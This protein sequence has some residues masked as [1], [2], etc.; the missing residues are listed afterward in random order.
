M[1]NQEAGGENV[2]KSL[3]P[4]RTF[5]VTFRGVD[6]L[7]V[8]KGRG[9]FTEKISLNDGGDESEARKRVMERHP[10]LPNTVSVTVRELPTND[11]FYDS[12]K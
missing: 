5:E 4:M 2:E 7:G 1:K 11:I 12:R 3:F 10:E 6:V 8:P 9:V